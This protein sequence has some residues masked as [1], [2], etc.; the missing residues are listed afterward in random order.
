[1]NGQMTVY[2]ADGGSR[3]AVG[4][5]IRELW[6]RRHLALDLARTDI[7]AAHHDTILGQ[8]WQLL[9]PLLLALV[10]LFLFEVIAFR[11]G[12]TTF[13]VFLLSGLFA[14]YF[15]RNSVSRG[16][17]A[18]TSGGA[19][20]TNTRIPRAILPLASVVF[21]VRSYGSAVLVYIP[22]HIWAGFGVSWPMLALI[23]IFLLHTM[24]NT[25]LAL[26]FSA[27]SV[28]FRDMRSALPFTMRL[29][30]YASPVL[31][32]ADDVPDRL[33][34]VLRANPLS[35]FI[36]PMHDILSNKQWPSVYW[37]LAAAAWAVGSFVLGGWVFISK[38]RDFAIRL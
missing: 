27:A 26:L 12:G 32:A 38:E 30:L 31:Y 36:S 8:L 35:A 17:M 1:M 15:T 6:R 5:Y 21:S 29:W 4:P 10:Y 13:V 34:A 14:F 11:S 33:Q 9:N 23:P 22:F 18:I 2:S 25:G 37:M 19:L 24:F 3:S 28:Y 16:S 7:K 20:V